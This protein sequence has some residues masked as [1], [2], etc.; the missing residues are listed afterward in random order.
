M[1]LFTSIKWRIKWQR[2]DLWVDLSRGNARKNIPIY[3]KYQFQI[4]MTHSW[5]LLHS[6]PF[7]I[8]TYCWIILFSASFSGCLTNLLWS[9]KIKNFSTFTS[10]LSLY[11]WVDILSS[12]YF[13]P[14]SIWVANKSHL[15]ATIVLR[16]FILSRA[17]KNQCMKCWSSKS[18]TIT[19]QTFYSQMSIQI[20]LL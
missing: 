16:W 11:K 7:V 5:H 12:T 8:H 18:K 9:A 1:S 17:P 2:Y 14:F 10:L 3:Q 15:M 4:Q 6:V 19:W 20:H 13:L